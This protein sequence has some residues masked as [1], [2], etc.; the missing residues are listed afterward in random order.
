[1]AFFSEHLDHDLL[2]NDK[3]EGKKETVPSQAVKS[4]KNGRVGTPNNVL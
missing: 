3:P 1:M 4:G 2:G